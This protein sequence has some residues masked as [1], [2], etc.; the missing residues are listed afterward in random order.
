VENG[1]VKND[2]TDFLFGRPLLKTVEALGINAKKAVS[3]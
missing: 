1:R 3:T 2:M